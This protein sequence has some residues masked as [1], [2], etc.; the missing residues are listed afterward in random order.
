MEKQLVNTENMWTYLNLSSIH[1]ILDEKEKALE[2]LAK[3]VDLRLM[4]GWHDYLEINPLFENLHDDPEFKA[5]VKRAQDEKAA[6]RAQVQ[7]MVDNGEID[8]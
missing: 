1:A 8:L 5:I 4:W 6:I 3:A 7:E 2:Y